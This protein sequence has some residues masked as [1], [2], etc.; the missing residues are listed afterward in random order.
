MSFN[1]ILSENGRF[2][3]HVEAGAADTPLGRA[4]EVTAQEYFSDDHFGSLG[5]ALDHIQ[6]APGSV[7]LRDYWE[8][9]ALDE[10]ANSSRAVNFRDATS[11]GYT[12]TAADYLAPACVDALVAPSTL[13][14]D[15]RFPGYRPKGYAIEPDQQPA[16][17]LVALD[18]S[19]LET[20]NKE[21]ADIILDEVW[22]L[23]P[24]VTTLKKSLQVEVIRGVS[25][26][27]RTLLRSCL[28]HNNTFV[29]SP[30][31]DGIK[32]WERSFDLIASFK[33]LYT[34]LS[35]E[36]NSGR[37]R[38]GGLRLRTPEAEIIVAGSGLNSAIDE[39]VARDFA[40][41]SLAE[42]Q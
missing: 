17:A 6:Q 2:I 36:P 37:L 22:S 31:D 3:T 32:R 8:N 4:V 5:F 33:A 42:L 1:H 16:M 21:A 28:L 9:A 40:R 10:L 35:G 18:P 7:P 14:A 24:H 38:Q 23:W 15:S 39:A 13:N 20:I 34:L 26:A 19:P 27:M 41:Q 12:R 30:G 29:E 11:N 25:P